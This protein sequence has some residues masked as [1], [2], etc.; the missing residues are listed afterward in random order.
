MKQIKNSSLLRKTAKRIEANEA[1][2]NVKEPN[3]FNLYQLSLFSNEN[4]VRIP[5]NK[6]MLRL[7]FG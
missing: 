2:I 5:K 4:L 7:I 3:R 1:I 6:L